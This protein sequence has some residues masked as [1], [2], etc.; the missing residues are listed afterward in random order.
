[1]RGIQLIMSDH[2]NFND[3]EKAV[4]YN[5]IQYYRPEGDR[6]NSKKAKL[7]YSVVGYDGLIIYLEPFKYCPWCRKKLAKL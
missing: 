2:C 1:M 3:F 4:D 6:L 5:D 7:V